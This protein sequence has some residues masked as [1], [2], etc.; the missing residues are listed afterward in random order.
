MVKHPL[1][2]HACTEL[3][4]DSDLK[5]R[6]QTQDGDRGARPSSCFSD[7]ASWAKVRDQCFLARVSTTC[8]FFSSV[9]GQLGAID[10]RR[11]YGIY[12]FLKVYLCVWGGVDV[13]MT[14]TCEMEV[15]RGSQTSWGWSC[16]SWLAW[17]H[18][19]SFP[20]ISTTS[21][22]TNSAPSQATKNPNTFQAKLSS[23]MQVWNVLTFKIKLKSFNL[24]PGE[25]AQWLRDYTAL[26]EDPNSIPSTHIGF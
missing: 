14:C 26:V 7:A 25:M 13:G 24:E 8:V 2:C 22:L 6:N 15:R 11:S 9:F 17:V 1:V 16:Y 18:P 19:S 3:S 4:W 21:I 5:W 23:F 20:P 12:E 10:R